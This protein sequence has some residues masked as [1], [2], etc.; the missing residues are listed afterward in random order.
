MPILQA[1]DS[2]SRSID[3]YALDLCPVEVRRSL[4]SISMSPHLFKHVR[5][6]GLIG[7]FNDARSWLQS[8]ENVDTPKCLVSLGSSIGNL[9]DTEAA[10]FLSGFA[11]TLCHRTD[12]VMELQSATA[13]SMSTMLV[14]LDSC[15]SEDTV[16]AA[17]DDGTGFNTSFLLNALEHVNT[18]LGYEVFRTKEWI[19]HGEWIRGCYKQY[20]VPLVD[21][22]FEDTHFE[23]GTKVYM[24]Q[25]QKYGPQEKARLWEAAKLRQLQGWCCRDVA[26]GEFVWTFPKSLCGLA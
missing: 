8:S 18:L 6:H 26:Y 12:S 19:V 2:M 13:R 9:T 21:V 24:V 20:L 16:R 1:L 5:C 15:K 10:E 7:T 23:A 4:A 25:S 3:Y 17:Y 14:G 11:Q 22:V